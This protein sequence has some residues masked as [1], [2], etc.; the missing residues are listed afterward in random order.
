MLELIK[1]SDE[2]VKSYDKRLFTAW[3]G[4]CLEIWEHGTRGKDH[5]VSIIET[6]GNP[7]H[8]DHKD[9]EELHNRNIST[10]KTDM[11]DELDS[12]NRDLKHYRL[13]CF[14][15]DIRR[16]SVDNFNRIFK[17]PVITGKITVN[18]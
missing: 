15:N 18:P 16:I 4:A 14:R 9:I 7:R 11:L 12:E 13:K 5:L 1:K 2:L 6:E 8:I 3:N 17:N 10:M